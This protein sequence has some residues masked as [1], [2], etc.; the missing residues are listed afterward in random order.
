[1]RSLCAIDNGQSCIGRRM[2]WVQQQCFV[3]GTSRRLPERA[4]VFGMS[5]FD[6]RLRKLP[7]LQLKVYPVWRGNL[8]TSL[9]VRARIS[10]RA[11]TNHFARPRISF[12]N[13][14]IRDCIKIKIGSR[15][16]WT[17]FALLSKRS[18]NGYQKRRRYRNDNFGK[19]QFSQ[20]IFCLAQ[21][22]SPEPFIS[23]TPSLKIHIL[24]RHSCITT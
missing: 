16:T 5:E 8:D 17:L 24:P 4:Y 20:R 6:N 22:V 23:Q 9:S 12:I 15:K 18:W 14:L 2:I 3:K 11:L 1:M 19:A 10:A 7:I 13:S 21:P